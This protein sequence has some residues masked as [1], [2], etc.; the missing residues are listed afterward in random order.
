VIESLKNVTS[1]VIEGLKA[2]PALLVVLFLN[3]VILGGTLYFLVKFGEANSRRME[4]ILKSCLP[5][6]TGFLG[7]DK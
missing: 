4:L 1:D 5:S 2:S 7:G 6:T 3:V